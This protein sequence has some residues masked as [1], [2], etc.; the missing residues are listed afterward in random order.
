[1]PS[2]SARSYLMKQLLRL[3]CIVVA[4]RC[5]L[6]SDCMVL[7][8][9][10]LCD[11]LLSVPFTDAA[12]VKLVDLVRRRRLPPNL[13]FKQLDKDGSGNVGKDLRSRFHCWLQ[14]YEGCTVLFAVLI[15]IG[16]TELR[17]A[18]NDALIECRDVVDRSPFSHQVR[19]CTYSEGCYWSATVL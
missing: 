8:Y 15:E 13:L 18:L 14:L 7:S 10:I 2:I 6:L 1:M 4:G 9:L 3:H 5:A 17:R 19:Y 16:A 11:R 12:I